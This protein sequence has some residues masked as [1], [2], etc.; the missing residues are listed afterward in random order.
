MHGPQNVRSEATISKIK[1]GFL[2]LV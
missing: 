2:Y 1:R